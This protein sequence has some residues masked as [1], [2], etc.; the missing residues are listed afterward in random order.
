MVFNPS[1][2]IKQAE[3]KQDDLTKAAKIEPGFVD[4]LMEM[5]KYRRILKSK[6]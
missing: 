5:F 4:K 6:T 2:F 1:A 3:R